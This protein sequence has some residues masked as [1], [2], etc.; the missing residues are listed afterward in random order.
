MFLKCKRI[1]RTADFSDAHASS[2]L[3]KEIKITSRLAKEY[4]CF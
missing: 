4:L 2:P 3:A 1:T